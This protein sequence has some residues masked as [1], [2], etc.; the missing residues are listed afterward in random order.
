M[1]KTLAPHEKITIAISFVALL[2]SFAGIYFSHFYESHELEAV[3]MEADPAGGDLVYSV[4][5][6]NPGNRKAVISE[7]WLG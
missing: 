2:A 3:V 6:I 1:K 7:A 4:A 5:I